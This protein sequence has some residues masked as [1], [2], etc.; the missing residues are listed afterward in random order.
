MLFFLRTLKLYNPFWTFFTR[1]SVCIPQVRSSLVLTP[2]KRKSVTLSPL[3]MAGCHLSSPE[4]PQSARVKTYYKV[5]CC[6]S[7]KPNKKEEK[8][9]ASLGDCDNGYISLENC[10]YP[11]NYVSRWKAARSHWEAWWFWD[12]KTVGNCDTKLTAMRSF[13]GFVALNVQ[14][15]V[16]VPPGYCGIKLN[17]T[18]P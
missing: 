8:A 2:K 1:L 4:S 9:R 11:L 15:F 12:G 16:K 10:F 14:W 17:H 13:F 18:D 7:S 5:N 3:M 6:H